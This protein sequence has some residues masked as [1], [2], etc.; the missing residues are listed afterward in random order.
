MT[1]TRRSIKT[2]LGLSIAA[3]MLATGTLVSAAISSE[4]VT[5]DTTATVQGRTSILAIGTK[6]NGPSP[7]KGCPTNWTYVDLLDFCVK[8]YPTSP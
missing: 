4:T 3:V 6:K 7:K 1:V 5:T 2:G 8:Q